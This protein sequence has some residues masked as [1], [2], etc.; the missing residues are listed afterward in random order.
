M[1]NFR[2]R[3]LGGEC[4]QVWNDLVG[5][6]EQVR[7]EPF[8]SEAI[9]VARE[10]MRRTRRNIEVLIPRLERVGYTFGYSWAESWESNWV[11]MQPPLLGQPVDDVQEQITRLEMAG[12]ILPLSLRAFYEIVGAV[13]FVGKPFS[14]TT[15]YDCE[16]IDPLYVYGLNVTVNE[17][18][19]CNGQQEPYLISICPDCLHKYNISGVGGFDIKIPS[20]AADA[21]LLFEYE[22][23]ETFV[24][25]L[26]KCFQNGGFWSDEP[27]SASELEYLTQGLL[28]I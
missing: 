22:D 20:F 2:E 6:K 23:I 5:L 12:L 28:K 7:E 25:Y 3:F 15:R 8:Y 16:G 4:E 24:A 11:E 18:H 9:A 13:N 10:T 14:A 17:Y 1:T 27:F 19:H 21:H 26:R